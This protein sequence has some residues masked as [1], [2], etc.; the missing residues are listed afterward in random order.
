MGSDCN[1]V[2]VHCVQDLEGTLARYL[3]ALYR[4]AFRQLRNHEDAEDAVQDALLSA[5]THISQFEGRSHISTWLH[6]IVVNSAR[7]H[8]RRRQNRAFVSI[9]ER[10]T[11]E[12]LC[13]EDRLADSGLNPEQACGQTEL[14]SMVQQLMKRLS[15][16]LESVLQLRHIDGLSTDESA[17]A[18]GV[19]QGTLK[20]R[21]Q[22]ARTK[23]SVLLVD[24]GMAEA[25]RWARMRKKSKTTESFLLRAL[26]SR[27]HWQS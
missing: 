7:M 5:F 14:D 15:P 4:V 19:K 13:M 21:A 12:G 25:V 8:L 27:T 11:E 26:S 18:L 10:E 23:L 22:R 24:R 6:R 20:S 3:P 1:I 17:R 16:K 2:A 9:D